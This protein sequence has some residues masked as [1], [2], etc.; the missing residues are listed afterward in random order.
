MK[1]SKTS[2]NKLLDNISQGMS[3]ENA[4]YVTGI[5]NKTYYLW[6]NQGKEDAENDTESIQ[7]KL[8][9]GIPAAQAI[10]E[11]MHLQNI[12]DAGKK[13]WRASAWFLEHTRPKKYGRNGVGGQAPEERDRLVVIG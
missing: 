9:E 12:A 1:L 7:R 11:Q 6:Y 13:N 3:I 2:I 8:F 4:C 10:C 5:C